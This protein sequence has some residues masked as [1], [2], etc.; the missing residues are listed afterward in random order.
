MA[1]VEVRLPIKAINLV[2]R[3]LLTL[4]VRYLLL[5]GGAG[6]GK[7]VFAAQ[8]WLLRVMQEPGHK[9]LLTRKF[10]RSIRESQLS[11]LT[12]LI[13]RYGL[14]SLFD[15]YEHRIVCKSG[16]EFITA[17][18]DDTEKLKSIH[19]VTGIWPEEATELDEEDLKQLDLRLR[20]KTPFYKQ[21]ILTFNPIDEEHWLRKFFPFGPESSQV[22][23]DKTHIL[24]TTYQDNAFIDEE[25]KSVLDDYR[26]MDPSYWE[27]YGLGNWGTPK[28][29]HI[30]T[31]EGYAE[32]DDLPS[33]LRGVIYCDPN[34]ALKTKGDSAAV[35]HLSFSPSR[36]K[37]FLVDGHCKSYADSTHLLNAVLA[38]RRASSHAVQIGFDGNVT[39]ESTWTNFVRDWCRINEQPFPPIEYKRYNVDAMVKNV[40]LAWNAKRILFPPGFRQA[41]QNKRFMAQLFAFEGKKAG[42]PD[43]APDA[44]ICAFEFI[45]EQA[46]N[47]AFSVPKVP[48]IPSAYAF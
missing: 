14:E 25:Y 30:F 15:I 29:G 19:G 5:Y 36:D 41:Q 38:Y 28:I 21:I 35:V 40:Q 39:Q 47:R 23:A 48:S 42:N 37:Y 4:P 10:H 45:H 26:L 33:D 32:Y 20:G 11:L 6:S 13:T 18:L 44:L 3:P 43:D 7:S 2:Y 12:G 17:G 34:L 31:P 9:I 24:K 1:E 27:V 46:L 8:K 16:G 22:K